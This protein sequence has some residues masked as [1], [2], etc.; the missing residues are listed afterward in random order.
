M[1]TNL[2]STWP[3]GYP[4][5]RAVTAQEAASIDKRATSQHGIPSLVLMEHASRGLARVA[6]EMSGPEDSFVCVCGPGNNGGDG[7]GAARFLRSWG[8][9]VDVV[10]AAPAEP[11]SGDA[12]REF[13]LAA[14]GGPIWDAWRHPDRVQRALERHPGVVLDALFGVG[15][16]RELAGP[17]LHWVRAL[18]AADVL[19][20]AVDVPSGMDSDTGAG[21]P[22]CVQA[23]VTATMAAPKRGLLANPQAAGHVVEI[24]I[25]LPAELHLEFSL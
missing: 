24:D 21:L 4:R 15:L 9:Q 17:F 8:R 18:N 5:H 3:P 12:L 22:E 6:L 10:R 25:G 1:G 20:L 14:A 2:P 13:Q 11:S 7:Y 23:H 16:T 19:R